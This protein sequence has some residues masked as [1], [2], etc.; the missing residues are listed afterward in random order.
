MMYK[1]TLGATRWT[2]L[3]LRLCC[4]CNEGSFPQQFSV[5]DLATSLS[6]QLVSLQPQSSFGLVPAQRR[7]TVKMPSCC[8]RYAKMETR[9]LR[10]ALQRSSSIKRLE[11]RSQRTKE[12]AVLSGHRSNGWLRIDGETAILMAGDQ[13][14]EKKS[15]VRS[16]CLCNPKAYVTIKDGRRLVSYNKISVHDSIQTD[17]QTAIRLAGDQRAEKSRV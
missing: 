3:S 9:F 10:R 6:R 1:V 8:E 4:S 5:L 17:G 11:S 7:G 14:A 15:P 16:L 2:L 12:T 13:R